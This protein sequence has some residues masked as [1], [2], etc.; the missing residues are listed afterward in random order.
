M[1]T[2][3]GPL[4][5]SLHFSLSWRSDASWEPVFNPPVRLWAGRRPLSESDVRPGQ[6]F[7][8]TA[9][10]EQQAYR[11]LHKLSALLI[12]LVRVLKKGL[13]Y[14]NWLLPQHGHA[15]CT[16]T[17]NVKTENDESLPKNWSSKKN[18]NVQ[19][20]LLLYWKYMKYIHFIFEVFY[21]VN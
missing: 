10:R 18:G 4:P 11:D 2:A 1:E 20:L 7:V 14:P 13:K 21:F 16:L 8:R 12:A 15:A 5:Q 6:Q 3:T 17:L 9:V 19:S